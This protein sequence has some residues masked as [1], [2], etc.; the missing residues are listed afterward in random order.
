[1]QAPTGRLLAFALLDAELAPDQL[2]MIRHAPRYPP[3]QD[4]AGHR[5]AA[6]LRVRRQHVARGRR[7]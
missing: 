7:L 3:L 2:A 4:S 6:N 5:Q 1:M